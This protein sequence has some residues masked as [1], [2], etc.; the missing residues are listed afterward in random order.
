MLLTWR[1]DAS[2]TG[3]HPTKTIRSLIHSF[4]YYPFSVHQELISRRVALHAI[5]CH[6]PIPA[7]PHAWWLGRT[8]PPP[9]WA[10][11]HSPPLFVPWRRPTAPATPAPPQGRSPS[12]P[13]PPRWSFLAMSLPSRTVARTRYRG[14]WRRCTMGRSQHLPWHEFTSYHTFPTGRPWSP[15]MPCFKRMFQVFYLGISHVVMAIYVFC[16]RMFQVFQLFQMYVS[17]VFTWMLQKYI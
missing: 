4:S 7:V 10:S 17:C 6:A 12:A 14:L 8:P 15:A 13:C 3:P 9:P 1:L 16:K 2:D 5:L 11:P